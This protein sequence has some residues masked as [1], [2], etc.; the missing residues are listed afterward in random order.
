[1]GLAGAAAEAVARAG[2]FVLRDFVL[3][4]AGAA[5]FAVARWR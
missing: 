2:N 4:L 5:A 3:P 1:L